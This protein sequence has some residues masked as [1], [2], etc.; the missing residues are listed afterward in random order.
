MM[1]FL[2]H[3]KGNLPLQRWREYFYPQPA[4]ISGQLAADL[5]TLPRDMAH[6]VKTGGQAA[7]LR[8]LNVKFSHCPVC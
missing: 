6:R 4:A 5:E 2:G 3:A 7:R 1:I 8:P